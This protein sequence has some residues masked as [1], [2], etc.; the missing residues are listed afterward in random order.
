MPTPSSDGTS[1]GHS[2]LSNSPLSSTSSSFSSSA[3]AAVSSDSSSSISALSSSQFS[4]LHIKIALCTHVVSIF[5]VI[6]AQHVFQLSLS[7]WLVRSFISTVFFSG[8]FV[9]LIVFASLSCWLDSAVFIIIPCMSR[10][11]VSVPSSFLCLLFYSPDDT[12]SSSS[13]FS[14]FSSSLLFLLLILFLQGVFAFDVVE[15]CWV[16]DRWRTLRQ[17]FCSSKSHTSAFHGLD[18]VCF[19]FCCPFR[20]PRSHL[21]FVM[22]SSS[23]PCRLSTLM[24]TLL[25]HFLFSLLLV[26]LFSLLCSFHRHY[27]N[28]TSRVLVLPLTSG[29]LSL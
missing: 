10:F 8:R 17:Q 2:G 29:K 21:C 22:P 27:L 28:V 5:R 15:R 25:I 4:S 13:C 9:L 3:A 7:T 24:L 26:P 12:S 14:F 11:L 19:P 18:P 23:F 20:F 16:F 6:A 1:S